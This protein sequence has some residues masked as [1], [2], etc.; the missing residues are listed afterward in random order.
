MQW[1][2]P[3]SCMHF[4]AGLGAQHFHITPPPPHHPFFGTFP[5]LRCNN[6]RTTTPFFNLRAH[7][8]VHFELLTPWVERF[9]ASMLHGSSRPPM[10]KVV[11]FWAKLT[12]VRRRALVAAW[13]RNGYAL[14]TWIVSSF[15]DLTFLLKRIN[16]GESWTEL[17]NF[18]RG[19]AVAPE[20]KNRLSH[21]ASRLT[22]FLCILIKRKLDFD[23]GNDEIF[24][25]W[26]H[27]FNLVA[28]IQS[29]CVRKPWM[30]AI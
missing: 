25:T 2:S 18:P 5:T 29:Y 9:P 7:F 8:P 26:R 6:F 21:F 20:K 27:L 16:F 12:H 14:W 24:Q 23:K 17:W 10:K 4:F 13:L 11:D 15:Q 22:S 3:S 30:H 28:A 1:C 19:K